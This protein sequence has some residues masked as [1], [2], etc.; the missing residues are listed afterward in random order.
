MTPI[1]VD[2]EPIVFGESW[3]P[4]EFRHFIS[5][6]TERDDEREVHPTQD[7]IYKLLE[8]TRKNQDYTEFPKLSIS[9]KTF[10]FVPTECCSEEKYDEEYMVITMNKRQGHNVTSW[11]NIGGCKCSRCRVAGDPAFVTHKFL[12]EV[13]GVKFEI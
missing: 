11:K 10:T 12:R 9:A 13:T 7:R 6:V 5:N 4:C 8:K 3:A 1:V 2:E